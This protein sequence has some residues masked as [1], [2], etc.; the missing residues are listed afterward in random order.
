MTNRRMLPNFL[1]IYLGVALPQL[2]LI[3]L[4]LLKHNLTRSAAAKTGEVQLVYRTVC[5]FYKVSGIRYKRIGISI[6]IEHLPVPADHI[7]IRLKSS[8]VVVA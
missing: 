6:L 8:R 4:L 5:L 1:A 2:P 3:H 7:V